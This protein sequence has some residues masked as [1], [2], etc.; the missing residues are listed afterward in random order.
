MLKIRFSHFNDFALL[1][2]KT[3]AYAT[4]PRMGRDYE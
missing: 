2:D 1:T 3:R 4:K